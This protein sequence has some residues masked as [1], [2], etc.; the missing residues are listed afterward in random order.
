MLVSTVALNKGIPHRMRY[1]VL[2][3]YFKEF[4]PSPGSLLFDCCVVVQLF[5]L[6]FRCV[7]GPGSAPVQT[8]QWCV[9][10]YMYTDSLVSLLHLLRS[11]SPPLQ[12]ATRA[13]AVACR[14]NGRR[15]FEVL[16]PY[17]WLYG[18]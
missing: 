1:W 16:K 2:L 13:F 8:P 6:L 9:C 7:A 18:A 14:R 15:G 11:D 5:V 3:K 4:R 17:F 12:R 10:I